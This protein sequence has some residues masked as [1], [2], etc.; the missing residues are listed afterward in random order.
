MADEPIRLYKCFECNRSRFYDDIKA[1]K[2][3]CSKCG[4][5]RVKYAPP[6]YRYLIPYVFHQKWSLYRKIKELLN[7]KVVYEAN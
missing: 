3:V 2:T 5:P 4:S 6:T 1:G 7:V